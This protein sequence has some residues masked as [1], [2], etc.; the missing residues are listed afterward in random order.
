MAYWPFDPYKATSVNPALVSQPVLVIGAGHDGIV[1]PPV[2]RVTAR[3]YKRGRYEL[4]P[5]ADHMLILG[6]ALPR[7]L[8]HI[9][10]WLT[11]ER[12]TP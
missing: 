1:A 2:G 11:D 12:L 6:P 5:E 10:Q 4:L 7:V 9:D 3:R 8:D